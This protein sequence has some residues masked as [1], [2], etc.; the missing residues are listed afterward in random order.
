[1]EEIMSTTDPLNSG[2]P[3]DAG[4]WAS[5]VDRLSAPDDKA[6]VGYNVTGRRAVGPQQGFGKLWQRTYATDLGDAVTV[7]EL[8]ADWKLHFGDYWPGGSVFHNTITGIAPGDVAPIEVGVASRG[9]KLATGIYVIY[10]DDESFTFM[11]PEG[12]MFAGMITFSAEVVDGRTQAEIKILIRP[13]DPL[14]ELAWPVA[15]RKEDTFWIGTVRNL[16]AHH[17]LPNATVTATTVCVD[18]KRLWPNWRN[19]RHNSGIRSMVH[20]LSTPLR[21]LRPRRSAR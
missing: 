7:K 4:N 2:A 11:T 20:L 13:N 5:K 19:I 9:P 3:R 8:I 15:R 21:W 6:D 10:A 17:G 18:R 16:A 14:W 12:H 1:V